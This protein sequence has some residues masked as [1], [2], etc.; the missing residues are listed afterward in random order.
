MANTFY[1]KDMSALITEYNASISQAKN[2]NRRN[3]AVPSKAE[4]GFYVKAA[5]AARKI[6]SIN[7]QQRAVYRQWA[8]RAAM[9]ERKAMEILR[10]LVPD[11]GK[12]T[13]E[14]QQTENTVSA[15]GA[16]SSAESS[17]LSGSAA[18][19][20]ASSTSSQSDVKPAQAQT[21]ATASGFT[22]R[23]ASED[24]SAETI[25][26]WYQEKP[27]HGFD[28]IVGM[29]DLKEIIQSEILD[30]IGWEGT[31]KLLRISSLKS[32]L[33]YGPFGTGKSFFIEAIAKELMDRGFKFIKLTG[34]DVHDSY[35]GVG[36]KKVKTAFLEAVDNAPCVIYFDEFENMCVRRDGNAEGHE[37]RLTVSF[38]ESY[39]IIVNADK[40]VVF[41]AATNYPDKIESAMLSRI[42]TYVLVPLPSEEVRC[43]YFND[44]FKKT[45]IKCSDD[46]NADIMADVTDN[47]SFRDLKKL[48][49]GIK[50]SIKRAAK[51]Q[52][53]VYDENNKILSKESDENT[54]RAIIEGK[55][56]L[57]KEM[58]ENVKNSFSPEKKGDILASLEAFEKKI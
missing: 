46:I 53:A 24:V 5:E 14:Q 15:S 23:N 38:M 54:S 28:D 19:A 3:G 18:A 45:E 43:K 17:T 9:N 32:F 57:T 8:E 4:Y 47:Y 41:L 37:K 39:N 58:F 44:F 51:E 42:L 48:T 34:S 52:F 11:Y 50:Q 40:P 25:E 7:V 56:T 22:T 16:D 10:V 2:T 33:F 30:N 21:K 55:L 31:D 12:K 29:E 1:E 26:K 36:E 20:P 27:K 13:E 49:D 6:S 35:V